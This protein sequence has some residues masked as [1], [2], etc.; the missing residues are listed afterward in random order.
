MNDPS[1]MC[2]LAEG[3]ALRGTRRIVD[4]DKAVVGDGLAQARWHY[5]AV[6]SLRRFSYTLLMDTTAPQRHPQTSE[7]RGEA[8]SCWAGPLQPF[9]HPI[10]VCRRCQA[11]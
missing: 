3:N 1:A 8:I 5:R 4:A 9:C 10:P 7:H 6:T 2:T 11:I